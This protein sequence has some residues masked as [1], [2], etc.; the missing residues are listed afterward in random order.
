MLVHVH[1]LVNG[2]HGTSIEMIDLCAVLEEQ[3]DEIC[4][5]FL[6]ASNGWKSTSNA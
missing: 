2:R 1:L 6:L 3:T 5:I 4:T